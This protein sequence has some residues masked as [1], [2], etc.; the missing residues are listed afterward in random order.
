MD[1][2]LIFFSNFSEEIKLIDFGLARRL[3]SYGRVSTMPVGTVRV[4]L[5]ANVKCWGFQI[6]EA[7]DA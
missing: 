3:P 4:Q 1:L 2:N 7:G 5:L 6:G